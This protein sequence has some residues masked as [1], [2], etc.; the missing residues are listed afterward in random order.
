MA[1]ESL[2]YLKKNWKCVDIREEI[3]QWKLK[4]I[5]QAGLTNSY[6]FAQSRLQT[7]LSLSTY[8]L[9]NM[10]ILLVQLIEMTVVRSSDEQT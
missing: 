3:I 4:G 10:I 9:V 8:L 1:D 5:E 2:V 7:D 6:Y